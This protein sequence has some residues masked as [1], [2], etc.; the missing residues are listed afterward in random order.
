M[1]I[2]LQ[3][4]GL[5]Y[6]AAGIA[7]LGIPAAFR[8]VDEVK[9]QSGTYW[10]WNPPL[11]RALSYS[12]IDTTVGSCL[13]LIGFGFQIASLT[14]FQSAQYV[15]PALLGALVVLFLLYWAFL[16]AYWSRILIAQIER[17]RHSE[18]EAQERTGSDRGD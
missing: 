14:G 2:D 10:N 18:A 8:M 9:A 13:L 12:R 4:I 7:I 16:R 11:A 17:Q 1:R 6:D 3:I 15:G 5:T